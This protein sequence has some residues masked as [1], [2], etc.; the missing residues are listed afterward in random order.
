MTRSEAELKLK[1]I[2]GFEKF[3]DEQWQTIDM[4]LRGERMLLIERTGYGNR[5]VSNF[6]LP[7]LMA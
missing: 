6:L 1:T 4:L 2:F 7:S 5:Y 3:Y